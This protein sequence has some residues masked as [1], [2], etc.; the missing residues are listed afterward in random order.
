MDLKSRK[1]IQEIHKFIQKTQLQL[2]THLKLAE[3]IQKAD[4]NL[5]KFYP[6]NFKGNLELLESNWE[7]DKKI[8]KHRKSN[9]E[10]S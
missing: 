3:K 10:H 7:F 5:Q 1:V 8:R 9:M 2:M 4:Q 6:E